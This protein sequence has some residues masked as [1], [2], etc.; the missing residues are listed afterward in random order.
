VR[1]AVVALSLTALAASNAA[2][3]DEDDSPSP[4]EARPTAAFIETVLSGP[5][6]FAAFEAEQA[7]LPSWTVSA[8]IGLGDAS[9]QGGAMTHLR[10]GGAWSRMEIG[11]GLSYGK[12]VWQDLCGDELCAQK[13]GTVLRANLEMGVTHRW[14]SGFS[15][16]YFVGYGHVAAG[17]LT[18]ESVNVDNCT[19]NLQNEGLGMVY[20][21]FGIGA[22]F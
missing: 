8:G 15:M 13:S 4:F 1:A 5:Y 7:L 14:P 10:F 22:S 2:A 9:L 11:A 16:K 17:S 19:A 12:R 21:G 18:C 3:A 20:T 6:G